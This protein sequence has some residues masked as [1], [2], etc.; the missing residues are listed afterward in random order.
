MRRSVQ[1]L[2]RHVLNASSSTPRCIPHI[3]PTFRSRPCD[4][5]ASFPL[6][7]N[8]SAT[9]TA[10]QHRSPVEKAEYYR[11]QAQEVTDLHPKHE[12][13]G[14]KAEI[15]AG[16]LE[17]AIGEAKELQARTPW[18]REGTDEPPVRRNRSAGAMVKGM[19]VAYSRRCCTRIGTLQR[20]SIGC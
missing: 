16:K 2:P 15:T 12:E 6:A 17:E 13:D 7:R 1:T 4:T 11:G 18:H 9:Y 3:T 8:F 19:V 5:S 20:Q 14:E 10:F